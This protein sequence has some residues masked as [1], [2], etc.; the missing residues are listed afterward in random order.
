MATDGTTSQRVNVQFL[1]IPER[2]GGV[3]AKTMTPRPSRPSD[4]ERRGSLQKISRLS[5]FFSTVLEGLLCCYKP[6]PSNPSSSSFPAPA[7]AISNSSSI[8]SMTAFGTTLVTL[9][10]YSATPDSFWSNG[11]SQ[12]GLLDLFRLRLRSKPILLLD[13]QHCSHRRRHPQGR[14]RRVAPSL[15]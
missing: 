13:Y 11:T 10:H 3:Y 6:P 1:Y 5:V 8:I 7:A 15:E 14:C 12:P 4:P 2:R 9:R